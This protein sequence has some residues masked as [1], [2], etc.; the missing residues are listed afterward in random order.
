ML[1]TINELLKKAY[2]SQASDLH[3]TVDSPPVYRINGNLILNGEEVLTRNHT[4][5]LAR[6]LLSESDWDR[7]M[8]E[9][10]IDTSYS[11]KN[12][13]RYRIN[14]YHQLGNIGIVARVVPQAIPS[15]E[16]LQMPTVLQELALKSQGLILVTGP[17]GSGKS[18]TM[19]AMIDYVNQRKSKHVIT[20]E[21]PIEFVH[22]H[23]KSI[24]NQ[25]E[26]GTDTQ[27]F[28]NG[29]RSALRQDP[30]IILVG[31][32]R[33]HTTISTALTAAETGHLVLAT[34]HTNSAAQ[35]INRIIDVFPPHQQA[36][37][38]IQ[39]AS[40][41][42]GVISQRLLPRTDGS[43]RIAAT[44]ILVNLPAVGNLIRNEK[45]DQIPN[46]LQTNRSAGMHTLEMSITNLLTN[47]LIQ[48]E[49]A[50]EFL[51]GVGDY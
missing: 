1:F 48:N 28:A 9:G 39:L 24:I 29:L 43:G 37:I 10:E 19:A 35:T 46:V 41:L 2:I 25:R 36:Q 34:L 17:T 40:V 27:S 23:K 4:E 13:S 14:V 38:R 32:M 33:D 44:E 12:V 18:T 16:Q 20:L 30:D 6:E 21:D 47:G 15:L 22:S 5:E 42:T 50:K 26:V 8:N 49:V 51:P 31:E 45:V 11:I 7:L 3:L